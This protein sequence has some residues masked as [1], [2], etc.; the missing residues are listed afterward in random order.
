MNILQ[1]TEEEYANLLSEL[2]GYGDPQRQEHNAP[3]FKK[4]EEQGEDQD[5]MSGYEPNV[6]EDEPDLETALWATFH[7]ANLLR[8]PTEIGYGSGEELWSFLQEEQDPPFSGL[9]A[10]NLMELL[11]M[12]QP[13]DTKE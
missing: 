9:Q 2:K 12:I 7:W 10:T 6:G 13:P 5:F 4:L 3:L 8:A 1:V 11:G